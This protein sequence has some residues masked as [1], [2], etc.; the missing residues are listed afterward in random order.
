VP[1]VEYEAPYQWP[2][3]A[4]SA[5]YLTWRLRVRPVVELIGGKL[6]LPGSFQPG[7]VLNR[8]WLR[9]DP[10]GEITLMPQ[11]GAAALVLPNLPFGLFNW[12]SQRIPEA[13]LWDYRAG[14][15]DFHWRRFP[16]INHLVALRTACALLPTL[17]QKINPT[18]LTNESADGLS[19][20]RKSGY[21]FADLEE[22]LSKEAD[23]IQGQVLDAWEGSSALAVL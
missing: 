5:G 3:T 1:P 14:M 7:V 22:R 9:V 16:Q 11:Y 10:L 8:D 6:V 15:Q 23:A 12:M 2:N 4:P 13:V 21:I 18:S 17:S 19:I 20:S